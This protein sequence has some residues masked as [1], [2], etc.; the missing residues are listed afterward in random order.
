MSTTSNR[1]RRTN[2]SL[3]PKVVK[4]GIRLAFRKETSLSR[5]VENF[6][7]NEVQK[8]GLLEEKA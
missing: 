7:R 8:A 3:D 4:A 2:L 1:R 5:I 6:L